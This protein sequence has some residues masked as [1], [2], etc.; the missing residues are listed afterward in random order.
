MTIMQIFFKMLENCSLGGANTKAKPI[1]VWKTARTQCAFECQVYSLPIHYFH[2]WGK[3]ITTN[4]QENNK[5]SGHLI[6]VYVDVY[7]LCW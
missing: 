1:L 4:L 7:R 6:A 3:E 5:T 2:A